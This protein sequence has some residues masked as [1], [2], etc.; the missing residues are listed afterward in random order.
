MRGTSAEAEQRAPQSERL[1]Q[2][3][4]RSPEWNGVGAKRFAGHS[5]HCGEAG[6]KMRRGWSC[7]ADTRQKPHPT[8][9]IRTRVF[10]SFSRKC[11]GGDGHPGGVCRHLN[12]PQIFGTRIV[13][14]FSS[15]RAE[16][17]CGG[18]VHGQPT[19]T[20]RLGGLKLK[21]HR[22]AQRLANSIQRGC[23]E[24]ADRPLHLVV[25]NGLQTLHIGVARLAEEP[26][27]WSRSSGA[28]GRGVSESNSLSA[29]RM[30]G[31][32]P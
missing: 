23:G 17:R 29:R 28:G 7:F 10:S 18:G 27:L 32:S 8:S 19:R 12:D 3:Q 11:V 22:I 6:L 15:A 24:A 31:F 5:C 20:V 4:R 9:S 25:L 30:R 1:P 13:L 16:T 14:R 26:L 21:L 2:P